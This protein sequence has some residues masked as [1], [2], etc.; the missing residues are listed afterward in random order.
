M[1]HSS[2]QDDHDFGKNNGGAE[3]HDRVPSQQVFL[4]FIDEPS[5]SPRRNRTGVY[6]SYQL[7]GS[8][9]KD[10]INLILLDVRYHKH[11]SM[12][13]GDI[14]G[15]EQWAWLEK[16][17]TESKSRFHIIGSGVQ[18]TPFQKP[19]QEAWSLYPHSR[20]R[21]FDLVAKLRTPGVIL[22][23]GDVHYS[24][25]LKVP[26]ECTG[27][28]YPVYEFT[29]SG[30]THSC[31]GLLGNCKWVLQ[32]FFMTPYHHEDSFYSQ[33]NWGA[34]K[35]DWKAETI[36]LETHGLE[37]EVVHASVIPFSEIASP[38]AAKHNPRAHL[39][40]LS[41]CDGE[42]NWFLLIPFEDWKYALF[43]IPITLIYLIY[44]M[45]RFLVILICCPSKKTKAQEKAKVGKLE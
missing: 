44:R 28:G 45:I 13:G 7:P 38:E 32:N 16:T 4:D 8:R 39:G 31:D 43:L 40:A 29:S 12:G 3:Y 26:A 27:T 33:R 11:G 22:L 5:N 14:L 18:V 25:V 10:D 21:L 35:F 9:G 17:L 6:A 15:D 37:G 30:L 24:E 42:P 1:A 19:V 41:K 2:L 23:S 20:Q 34:L 36:T